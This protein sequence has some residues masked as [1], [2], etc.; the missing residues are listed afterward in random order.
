MSRTKRNFL[1]ELSASEM[2]KLLVVRERLDVLEKKRDD[3]VRALEVVDQ[4]LSKLLGGEGHVHRNLH[5]SGRKGTK[6]MAP[7]ATKNAARKV[8]TKKVATGR[9][10]IKLEDVVLEILNQNGGPMEFKEILSTIQKGKL[11]KTKSKS[12]DNVLRRT[13]S[14]SEK[15]K[16]VGRGIYAV[17]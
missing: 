14:T 6:N 13:L 10:R 8:M 5:R 3:L 17:G 7:R 11:Y 4:E 1:T 16:R 12:F 2:K 9:G 15:V